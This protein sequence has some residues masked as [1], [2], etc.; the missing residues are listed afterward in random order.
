VRDKFLDPDSI[1]QLIKKHDPA[2]KTA[3]WLSAAENSRRLGTHLVK[4]TAGAV[5]FIEDAAIQRLIM[6]A[7]H[8]ALDKI[9]LSQSAGMILEV[10]TKNNRHQALLDEGINQIAT[11]LG[12]ET[13]QAIIADGIVE[14]LKDEHPVAEKIMPSSWLGKTGADVA[15]KAA[16]RLLDDINK[17]PEHP[18]RLSFDDYT[19]D[20]IA[21]LKHDPTFFAK[22]EEIKS[23]LKNDETFNNYVSA[24]WRDIK[25]W[26]KRDC[27]DEQS[28]L[29]QKISLAGQW[30]GKTLAEDIALRDSLNAHMQDAAR[31]MAPDFAQFLTTHISDTVKSWDSKDM[32]EQI[33]LNIGKDL[34]YIR[35][36]G[37]LVGGCIGCLLYLLVHAQEFWQWLTAY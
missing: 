16:S 36:N 34:Q 37:T 1:V 28:V 26:L 15:V 21:R 20:F 8:N 4:F 12:A 7:I 9:D 17:N 5:D 2:H 18:L 29:H 3:Q 10:M 33:E 14:W 23:Y 11:L 31:K 35:I 19:Q 6:K 25:D 22:A 30:L 24:V 13:T 27:A 32:A